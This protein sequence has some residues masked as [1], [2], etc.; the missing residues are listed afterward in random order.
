MDELLLTY[1]KDNFN[2][3]LANEIHISFSLMDK[4][5]LKDKYSNLIDILTYVD[6]FTNNDISD[7]FLNE[8]NAKLDFIFRENK[9]ELVD[10]VSLLNKN[11]LLIAL[12]NLMTLED[13]KPVISVLESDEDNDTK[14]ATIISDLC[15]L[16]LEQVLLLIDNFD[17]IILDNLKSDI[18]ERESME[19]VKLDDIKFD[20]LNNFR[21]FVKIFGENNLGS[22]LVLHDISIGEDLNYYI[23]YVESS[24]ITDKLEQTALNILS[25]IYLTI[26]GYKDPI[27]EFKNHSLEI[28]NDMKI[29]GQIEPLIINMVA[30]VNELK[31]SISNNPL[32]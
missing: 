14:L 17:P 11:K 20:V 15:D 18:Y 25:I 4:F 28:L 10:N 7:M 21:Y 12:S 16:Y 29:I 8:I 13:Y 30:K 5:E 27:A 2:D 22:I 19:E 26:E 6:P 32:E 23:N 3:E 9:I 24:I 1:I 31:N